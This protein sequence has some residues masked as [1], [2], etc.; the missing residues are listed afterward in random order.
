MSRPKAPMLTAGQTEQARTGRMVALVGDAAHTIHPLAGQGVNL[1]FLDCASL[2]QV[3][4]AASAK[5]EELH[6]LRVLR[7]YERWRRSENAVVMGA[8]DSINRLFTDKSVAI[9]GLRRFGLSMVTRQPFLRRK[10][11]ERALG[12]G[13]DAPQMAR[14]IAATN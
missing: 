2:V 11:V 1:G 14:R 10:L 6:G 7:R 4:A 12:V 5:G 9:A 8:C 3:L 13:G